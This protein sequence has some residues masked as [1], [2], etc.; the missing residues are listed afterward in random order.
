M[1]SLTLQKAL[2][3]SS[4][5]I[6]PSM[7]ATIADAKVNGVPLPDIPQIRVENGV[8]ADDAHVPTRMEIHSGETHH[9]PTNME[10]VSTEPDPVPMSI[11]SVAADPQ[12][13]PPPNEGTPQLPPQ[14][15]LIEDNSFT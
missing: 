12:T 10:V 5:A 4:G 2:A 11:T 3:T 13:P 6:V 1:H 14:P 7:P 8:G 9:V 15:R